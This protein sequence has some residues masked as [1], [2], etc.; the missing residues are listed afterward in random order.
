MSENASRP[1][2]DEARSVHIQ[3]S[4]TRAIPIYERALETAPDD[5]EILSNYGL[6]LLQ[7]G[8]I[9]EA[10]RPLRRAVEKEPKEPAFRVNLAELYFKAG[11][12]ETAI[13]E[14]RATTAANPAFAPAFLRLGHALVA[15]QE[16]R[17]A[18][19]AFDAALQL[20]PDDLATA[21]I[22][23][24][25]LAATGNYGAAYHVLDHAEKIRPD[26]LE[27]LRLRLEIARTRRDFSA[28]ESLAGNLI[29]LA[30]DDPT[31]WRDLAAVFF[32][33]GR[34]GDALTA[35]DRALTMMGKNGETLSQLA[36]L[37]INALEFDRAE[38][39]LAEAEA[40]SPDH[41]R[42]LSTKALL[43]TYQGRKEEALD[44]CERCF[45]AD[46][47]FS[48]IYPQLSVLR[49]G[50]LEESE[51]TA[52]RAYSE[53]EDVAPGSRATASFVVAHSLDARGAI[54]AAFEQ[55]REANRLAAERNRQDQIS[56]DF[57][58]HTAWTD[59]IIRVFNDPPAASGAPSDAGP[60]PIFIVGLPRS[61]STLVESVI[62]AHSGVAAG[63]ELPMM[64]NIFNKWL[65]ENHRAGPASISPSERERHANAYMAGMP[66]AIEKDRFTDKNLLNIE[67]AGF[68]ARIFPRAVI[69]NVRRDPVEGGLSIWRHDMLKFWAYATNFEDIARRY[70]LYAKLVDHFERTLPGRF[71]TVQYED[72]VR[73]FDDRARRLI[74]SCGLD[75]EESCGDFQKAREI[76]PTM[77]AMQVR[78][79][80]SLKGDRARLYGAHLDPLR[81]ALEEAGVDL[82]TG[83][84]KK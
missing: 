12:A 76:A 28:M 30:P 9:A 60:G 47:S 80:V 8:R 13:G 41:P 22:L 53:R 51:E 81:R 45:R 39:A 4:P 3:G 56:Y 65:Q 31:G 23:A 71:H 66:A 62:A 17:E 69:I 20:R 57:V 19:E 18:A 72:F 6:A 44:Y 32:E 38:R 43:L 74:N 26:D 64:P 7:S 34:Y 29:R 73:E 36:A 67:A 78:E 52:I 42:V 37:A 54:D 40:L 55:Y 10:E 2:L 63:G 35:F 84:L 1:I 77:S 16:L 83:A 61:G 11:D 46:P 24:R 33:Q 82:D 70:G 75:W 15:R 14:L 21:L 59:A 79:E 48:G 68:I 49:N 58:G 5:A 25:A 27:T 50:R